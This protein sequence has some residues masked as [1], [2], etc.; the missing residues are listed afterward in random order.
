M[1]L[2][3]N[4]KVF[5]AD[6]H[7]VH[8][9]EC[10]KQM[11]IPMNQKKYAPLVAVDGQL[12]VLGSVWSLLCYSFEKKGDFETLAYIRYLNPLS[13]PNNIKIGSELELYEGAKKVAYG[14]VI[15]ETDFNFD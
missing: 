13:N 15:E 4:N 6:I 2:L 8:P 3:M 1:V 14:K 9:M 5:I 11:P 7:W 10:G 12:V